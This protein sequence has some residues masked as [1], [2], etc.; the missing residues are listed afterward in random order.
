MA[1]YSKSVAIVKLFLQKEHPVDCRN[2]YGRQPLHLAAELG[3]PEIASILIHA[4]SKV[5]A[6]DKY[7]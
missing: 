2:N 1:C 3:L 6:K 4:G 5:N 7:F